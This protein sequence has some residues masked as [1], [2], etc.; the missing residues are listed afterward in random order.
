MEPIFQQDF[1][2]QDMCVDRYGRLKPSTLLYFAQEIAGRHCDE[3]AD[4]LESHR[5]FWA[6]TRHRY[7]SIG[8]RNGAR[9]ST[10]RPGLCQTP[11]SA[12]PA[13]W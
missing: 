5:L 7:R 11:T 4:T 1:Q 9:P 13:P 10:L 12:T 8:S 3:L 6:V 2:V